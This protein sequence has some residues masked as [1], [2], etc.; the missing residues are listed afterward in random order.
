VERD[1]VTERE[2]PLGA[3]VVGLP[4]RGELG[5]DLG[6]AR[7]D[8]EEALEHLSGD[9]EGLAVGGVEGVE[10]FGST[11]RTEDERA[12]V[13]ATASA[14]A[15]VALAVGAASEGGRCQDSRGPGRHGASHR[16]PGSFRPVIDQVCP[17]H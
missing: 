17:A 13:A 16:H 9:A 2:G 12:V 4:L 11:G 14:V 1:V 15:V 8:A 7:L 6:A 5:H 10:H 3:V